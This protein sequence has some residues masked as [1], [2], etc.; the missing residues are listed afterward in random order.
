[1]HALQWLLVEELDEADGGE[2]FGYSEDD[3]LR[4]DPE[5]GQDFAGGHGGG[6]P[7][8]LHDGGGDH[9]EG[10]EEEA[11]ADALQRSDAVGLAG[12]S[13]GEGDEEGVVERD[14]DD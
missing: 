13:D 5:D 10:G 9:G 4:R 1:M 2:H 7:L 8:V 14:D 11:E 6:P 3:V 12:D